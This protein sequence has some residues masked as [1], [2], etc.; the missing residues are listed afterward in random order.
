MAP[1]GKVWSISNQ[2]STTSGIVIHNPNGT[3]FR[4]AENTAKFTYSGTTAAPYMSAVIFSN[5][6]KT[7]SL[8]LG[9]GIRTSQDG[10]I[11]V[12]ADGNKIVKI[13]YQTGEPIAYYETLNEAVTP[14]AAVAVGSPS[15]DVNGN[16][17]VSAVSPNLNWI[18]KVVPGQ[19]KMQ[20]VKA[21]FVLPERTVTAGNPTIRTA[22]I[23]PDGKNIYIPFASTEQAMV[24][25]SSTNGLDWTFA[26][27]ITLPGFSNTIQAEPD[28]RVY[29]VSWTAFGATNPFKF[30]M[31]D[32]V[33]PKLSWSYTLPYLNP[34]TATA[35]VRGMDIKSGRDTVYMI[36]AQTGRIYRFGATGPQNYRIA[37]TRS[38]NSDGVE[39]NV[40]ENVRLHGVVQSASIAGGDYN[41]FLAAKND[42]AIQVFKADKGA[43]T[44]AP[45]LGDSIAVMGKLVQNKGSLRV[46]VDSIRLIAGNQPLMAAKAVTTLDESSEGMKVRLQGAVKLVDPAQWTTGQ[47]EG[48]FGVQVRQ[49]TETYMVYIPSTS[50]LYSMPAPTG[51]L[52]ISGFVVQSK[53]DAPF[54]S[55]YYIIATSVQDVKYVSAGALADR[56][57]CPGEA[58]SLPVYAMGNSSTS[59]VTVE[60]SD[61]AGSFATPR[62]IGTY[63]G[64]GNGNAA[65]TVP[66]VANG[67]GYRIR[68]VLDDPALTTLLPESFSITTA[69]ATVSQV[70]NTLTASEGSAYQWF[71]NGVA[72]GAATERTYTATETGRY[73]VRVGAAGGCQGTSDVTAVTVLTSEILP[74]YKRDC[75]ERDPVTGE[76]LKFFSNN[77][78]IVDIQSMA[79]DKQSK[80]WVAY[81]T[82]GIAVRNPD[83]TLYELT[84]SNLVTATDPAVDKSFIK[85]IK[86]KT[87]TDNAINV[88]GIGRA[89]D[90]NI[91]VLVNS[92]ILYKLD[93]ITGEPLARYVAPV[94]VAGLTSTAD[95]RIYFGGVTV[96]RSFIVKQSST[97]PTTFDVLEDD[98]LLP[99]RVGFATRSSAISPSGNTIFYSSENS[100]LSLNVR[101]SAGQWEAGTPV[102]FTNITRVSRPIDDTRFFTVSQTGNGAPAMLNFHDLG[103]PARSW[104]MA[105]PEVVDVHANGT[106]DLRGLAFSPNFDTVYVGSAF[107]GNIYRYIAQT[108]TNYTIAQ[109]RPVNAQGVAEKV[110]EYVRLNGVVSTTNMASTGFNFIMTENGSAI[111]VFKPTTAGIV[112]TPTLGNTIEVLGTLVQTNGM[113]RLDVDY[114]KVIGTG[115]T[116][117]APTVITT[118]LTEAN[119]AMPVR[120]EKVTLVNPAAWTTGQGAGGF[121]V[122]VMQGTETYD[123]MI[124]SNSPLY[125]VAAPGGEIQIDGIVMQSDATSPFTA[126]YY[127][128]PRTVNDVRFASTPALTD[129]QFCSGETVVLPI[130]AM[131]AAGATRVTVEMSDKAG[132]FAAARTVGTYTTNGAGNVTLTV[133]Q[134]ENGAGY[135][136][137]LMLEN[138]ALT[139][140]VP[141][142][143]TVTTA[144]VPTIALTQ[145]TSNG[146]LTASE[147]DAYQW[148]FNG[149]AVA[150]PAGTARVLT[151]GRSGMYKVEV[152]VNGCSAVSADT[153]VSLTSVRNDEIAKQVELYPVP[154]EGMLHLKMPAS[155][156]KATRVQI[157]DLAG[158]TIST[159]EA[160]GS[161]VLDLDLTTQPAGVYLVILH[162][163]EGRI[164]KRVVK[165]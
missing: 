41:F 73:S 6:A 11:L 32:Q 34:S 65:V 109:V 84:S 45:A 8:G 156:R 112:Y 98:F 107:S 28:G 24:K 100:T 130:Y 131:G 126:G 121:T 54:T 10:N 96:N 104:A 162:T 59:T 31:F 145:G 87:F 74:T 85:Q 67:T 151:I 78:G 143:I 115:G 111:Q 136:L 153:Q 102:T 138:P 4:F 56:E 141:Q 50:P 43:M 36:S 49:G 137:R 155:V 13:N 110:G 148:Y 92:S 20:E 80:L 77:T 97:D 106:I 139:Y 125:N 48:G 161:D 52:E 25:F 22:T 127:I 79:V 68:L 165:R 120:L 12:V 39:A 81:Y 99:S 2:A 108:P 88:T 26:E 7:I 69:V 117:A 62:V 132:S 142:D 72:I 44:Y 64:Q 42:G 101:N 160:Q 164:V 30:S 154:T 95:G 82:K 134:V 16:I 147:G 158:R 1:D 144:P 91:L 51:E 18:V 116:V 83:N 38:A 114:I 37:E 58:I 103:T 118:A 76:C 122:Q 119:E 3:V 66:Q 5:P 19:D 75:L 150:A 35:D 53:E 159:Q 149:T 60:M 9:R 140:T 71:R 33:N 124:P 40:N 47:G 105:L 63:T 128:M 157:T 152:R 90:G 55:G 113:L 146:T 14:A 86:F 21:A 46:E 135:R 70:G 27:K 89:H 17:F 123:V 94:A 163:P 93:A 29:V 23:S 15:D 57:W 133:P 61:A 129:V